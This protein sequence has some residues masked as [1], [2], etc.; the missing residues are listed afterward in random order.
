MPVQIEGCRLDL[1]WRESGSRGLNKEIELVCKSDG[2]AIELR[3][4][5]MGNSLSASLVGQFHDALDRIEGQTGSALVIQGAGRHLC[6]GF[7]LSDAESLSDGDLLLRFVRIEQLLARLWRMPVP[8]IVVGKG[9]VMGAGADLFAACTVRLAVAGSSYAFP[10]A[11][12]G[13]VLGTR[14]LARR[15]GQDVAAR[16][17]MSGAAITAEDAVRFGLASALIAED[18]I[19]EAVAAARVH[20]ARVDDVTRRALLVQVK[21]ERDALDADLA[22]LV[23]SAARPGLRE[24]ILVYRSKVIGKKPA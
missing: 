22:A 17:A 2:S 16:L 23:R 14:R 19:E 11:G 10:G 20:A 4:A 7:D 18:G 24:R 1:C 21:D 6:T 5:A 12:F 8:V 15:V 9:Q 3:R 13:L